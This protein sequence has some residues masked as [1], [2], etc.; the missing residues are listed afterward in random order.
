MKTTRKL[1]MAAIMVIVAL[2][3]FVGSTFAWMT[4]ANSVT[5][6]TPVSGD[7]QGAKGIYARIN[8]NVPDRAATD[9]WTSE[10]SLASVF[11]GHNLAPVSMAPTTGGTVT[12][13]D[14]ANGYATDKFAKLVSQTSGAQ[15]FDAASAGTDYIEFKVD[16]YSDSAVDLA[17]TVI[18][19]SSS[20]GVAKTAAVACTRVLLSEGSTTLGAKGTNGGITIQEALPSGVTGDGLYN[21]YSRTN[22]PSFASF[23]NAGILAVAEG[24][25]NVSIAETCY[26]GYVDAHN[27]QFS[28]DKEATAGTT[29]TSLTASKSVGQN[30]KTVTIRIYIEGWDSLCANY[31]AKTN[32]SVSFVF[33]PVV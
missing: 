11:T 2:L 17:A 6:A 5:T 1:T 32:I 26:T 15:H 7:I 23:K 33:A 3:A 14:A 25:N 13:T 19:D 24:T 16:F 29:L 20:S 4:V 21:F 8:N 22:N 31:I 28:G 27:T 9:G 18:I 12:Y 10:L 30:I